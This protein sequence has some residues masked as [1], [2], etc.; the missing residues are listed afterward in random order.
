M[1]GS[2]RGYRT[3]RCHGCGLPVVLCICAELPC[4]RVRLRTTF[5][6][7]FREW[8]KPTNTARVAQRM[9]SQSRVLLRGGPTPEAGRDA[10]QAIESIPPA[11][12][13]LLF[14]SPES[15]PIATLGQPAQLELVVPDGTW[16]QTRRL[17]RRHPV[18]QRMPHVRLSER[19]T[20]YRLR[21]GATP[22]LLCTLEAVA[23]ALAALEPACD[24]MQLLSGFG[25][26][27]DRALSYRGCP[28]EAD[29]KEDVVP[30]PI[31]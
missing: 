11:N 28:A 25:R 29:D 19:D 20:V 6:V 17:V 24:Y 15:L 14:P 31:F 13:V 10:E 22:G 1:N 21:R 16:S 23:W 8:R 26:W 7:H 5:I 2:G 9:L 18:L 27:Q 30:R 4:V 12:A 3:E